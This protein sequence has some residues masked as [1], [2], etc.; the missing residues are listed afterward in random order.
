MDYWE[1]VDNAEGLSPDLL[2]LVQEL[3][4]YANTGCFTMV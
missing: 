4:R 3:P 1:P 2:E